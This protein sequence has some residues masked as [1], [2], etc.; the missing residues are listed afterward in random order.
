MWLNYF[1]IFILGL[2][3]GSFFNV[4]IYRWSNQLSI[5]SPPFSFCPSCKNSIRWY[6]NIPVISYIWLKGK[7]SFCKEPISP[8]Y[9]LVEILTSFLLLI[10]YIYFKKYSLFTFFGFSI[11]VLFLIPITFI[12]LYIKEIPDKLSLSLIGVGWIF[13]LT[14]YNFLIDFKTSLLSS[15]AGIGLLFLINEV[16]Y[17]I[18]KRDGIG[19]G[20]FKLM[21]GIGAFL[22]WESFFNVIFL[23]SLTGLLTYLGFYFFNKFFRKAEGGLELKKEI[24]FGP[25][26]SLASLLYLFGFNLFLQGLTK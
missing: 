9:P 4:L 11:F 14:G 20:D 25:F 1:L 21:G 23:A 22:G 26:L 3:I 2:C 5:L 6:Y 17:Q 13:S 8:V 19:M 7:C 18:S 10:S 15:L 12:D 16:Y 24:P